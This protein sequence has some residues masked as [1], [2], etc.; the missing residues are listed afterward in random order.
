MPRLVVLAASVE[1]SSTRK[2][3]Q[4]AAKTL[5]RDCHPRG[6]QR[7]QTSFEL[8]HLAYSDRERV[9]IA[10]GWAIQRT[11]GHVVQEAL[12][13]SRDPR[14]ALCPLKCFILLYE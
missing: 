2:D 11:S 14:D 7:T 4:T 12:L 10:F 5:P 3:K 9:S 1:I 8:L 6:Q 13:S